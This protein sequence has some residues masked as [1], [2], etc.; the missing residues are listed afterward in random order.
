MLFHTVLYAVPCTVLQAVP[1]A[2][3]SAVGRT[4]LSKIQGSSCIFLEASGAGCEQ[5]KIIKCLSDKETRAQNPRTWRCPGSR[6][7]GATAPS[8]HGKGRE[9]RRELGEA[10]VAA[11]WRG[12]EAEVKAS[13]ERQISWA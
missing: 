9:R 7:W 8:G 6:H 2:G 11:G 13:T 3:C 1:C 5:R 12:P 4:L 10:G